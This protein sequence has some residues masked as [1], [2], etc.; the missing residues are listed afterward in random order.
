MPQPFHLE[1][2]SPVSAGGEKVSRHDFSSSTGSQFLQKRID[3]GLQV[4]KIK[5]VINFLVITIVNTSVCLLE[6]Y[7]TSHPLE[8]LLTIQN[9]V[10]RRP[11]HNICSFIALFFTYQ[12]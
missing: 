11:D 6:T 12:L 10:A 4:N 3:K 1:D 5:I 2:F 8:G 9:L 7:I